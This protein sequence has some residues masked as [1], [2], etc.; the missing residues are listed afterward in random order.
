MKQPGRLTRFQQSLPA[1]AAIV[2][3]NLNRYYL[4]GFLGTAGTLLVT[5]FTPLS[6]YAYLVFILLYTPCVSAVAAIRRETGSW[7]YTLLSV[8]MQLG[9]AYVMAL[10]VFQLGSLLGA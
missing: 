7:K 5:K 1:Q 4:S 3:S 6:A 9:V 2:T 8:L 10:L